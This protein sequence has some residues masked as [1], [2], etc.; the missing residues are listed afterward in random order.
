MADEQ[1]DVRRKNR[2]NPKCS[3]CLNCF[4]RL[5]EPPRGLPL[6]LMVL[7]FLDE[8]YPGTRWDTAARAS[9]VARVQM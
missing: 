4:I 9:P 6:I 8:N 2:V 3:L 5:L 1:H 7:S